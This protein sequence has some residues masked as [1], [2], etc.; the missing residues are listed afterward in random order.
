MQMDILKKL[1]GGDLRSIGNARIIVDLVKDQKAFDEL[2]KG[3]FEE[4]RLIV[5]RAAD[6]IEKIT[7]NNTNYLQLHKQELLTLLDRS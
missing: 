6:V 4:D 2:F 3:L 1:K 5:M 7:S